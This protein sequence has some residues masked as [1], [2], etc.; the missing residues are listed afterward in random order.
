MFSKM[1]E[2]QKSENAILAD[3]A[4]L[5]TQDLLSLAAASL[6]DPEIKKPTFMSKVPGRFYVT[7]QGL[8]NYED[9]NSVKRALVS[10]GKREALIKKLWSSR[11][12]PRGQ[13]SFSNYITRRYIGVQQKLIREFVARQVGVQ[14]VIPLA[15]KDLRKRAIRSNR[16]FSQLSCDLADMISFSDVRGRENE[17]FVFLLVDNF[18]GFLYQAIL[19]LGKQG[20]GVAK[21][22]RKILKKEEF[23]FSRSSLI[24]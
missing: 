1:A 8:L 16:P 3:Y 24:C 20:V 14:M 9:K 12:V 2:N 21:E 13:G 19:P 22:Y 15:N 23:T 10:Q 6:T 17:R 7:K 18:S 11:I 4:H 5:F